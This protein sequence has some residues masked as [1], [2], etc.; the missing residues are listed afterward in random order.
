MSPSIAN[1]RL[2]LGK[3][4]GF[5]RVNFA[6]GGRQGATPETDS[7]SRRMSVV[8]FDY[9]EVHCKGPLYMPKHVQRDIVY[10]FRISV[11]PSVRTC[12]ILY[13]TVLYCTVSQ[14]MDIVTFLAF[15]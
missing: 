2:G 3:R 15:W 1:Y 11:R 7:D 13:C 8:S 9:S 14:R 10:Q 4:L 6:S 12:P 5:V